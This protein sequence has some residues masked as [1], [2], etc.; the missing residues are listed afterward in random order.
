MLRPLINNDLKAD[1]K[2]H[3]NPIQTLREQTILN[4]T[5]GTSVITRLVIMSG[6]FNLCPFNVLNL[7]G[8][9]ASSHGP[10]FRANYYSDLKKLAGETGAKSNRGEM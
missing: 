4:L 2:F 8:V 5:T 3:E 6:L 10:I 9:K 1:A 7:L